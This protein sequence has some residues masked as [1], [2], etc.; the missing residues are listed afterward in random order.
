MPHA[1]RLR[2]VWGR[3]VRS[4]TADYRN[5]IL[6]SLAVVLVAGWGA[7]QALK[8]AER[9]AGEQL[10]T[11]QAAR[12][13]QI[14]GW[15]V[16]R[17]VDLR[18]LAAVLESQQDT[19]ERCQRRDSV[20][21]AHVAR[22]LAAF[23]D[24][25]G[26]QGI[27]WLS[28]G[29]EGTRRLGTLG[30]EAVGQQAM[31]RGQSLA[32]GDS[33]ML[34][35]DASDGR[36]T[37]VFLHRLDRP[38]GG[39]LAA[40]VD[41]SPAL[42]GML[43]LAPVRKVGTEVVLV[44][45][46]GEHAIRLE[47]DGSGRLQ[48]QRHLP[49]PRSV[50]A[51]LRSGMARVDVPF[52]ALDAQDREV[53]AVGNT[54]PR[55]DW[56][57]LAQRDRMEVLRDALPTLMQLLL[58]AILTLVGIWAL[59]LLQRQ[60]LRLQASVD[61]AQERQ[62][63]LR[64]MDLLT[65]M[66][67]HSADLIFV[68]D[69]EHRY[70]LFNPAAQRHIGM[71]LEQVL[72]RRDEDLLPPEQARVFSAQDDEVLRR[73]QSLRWDVEVQQG[74]K[75]HL[76]VVKSP[77]R[78]AQGQVYGLVGIA[79]DNTEAKEAEERLRG[80]EARFRALFEASGVAFFIQDLMTGDLLEA[81]LQALV[82]ARCTTLDELAS[83][84][85]GEPPYS[86]AD[87][88]AATTRLRDAWLRGDRG[89]SLR[90]E[91][92]AQRRDG[93]RYWQDLQ[94]KVVELQGR[95][96]LL[97][98]AMNIDERKRIES[99][100]YKL[101]LA[102]DQ[103]PVSALITDPS[104][105]IEYAN[106]SFMNSSGYSPR[107]VIGSKAN[108]LSSGQT[109]R[110]TYAAMWSALARGES[111]RGQVKNRRKNGEVYTDDIAIYPLRQE[112]GR[113]SHYVGL[114][115][116]ISQRLAMEGELE[117]H[118]HHLEDLIS[119]RTAQL[120]EATRRAEEANA[121]KSAFLANMSHEIRTPM[122]AV[123]GS[124]RLIQR[125]LEA[126]REVAPESAVAV[127]TGRVAQVEHAARHLLGLLNDLLDLSKIEANKLQL[128]REDFA[129]APLV[130]HLLHMVRER[131][132]ANRV[133]LV[134]DLEGV[135]ATLH[136]DGMRVS[137]MLL[138]LLANAVRFTQD[139][140]VTLRARARRAEDAVMW[141]RFEV[142]DEGIGIDEEQQARLFQAFGQAERDTARRYGG[143]GLGLAIT[144]RLAELMAGQV[145]VSS[146]LGEGSCFWLD[147]PLDAGHAAAPPPA[148]AQRCDEAIQAL[149]RLGPRHVLLVDDMAIN[150]DIARD[151]LEDAG[152]QVTV[153]GDGD[154]AVALAQ[155]QSFDLVLMDLR[156]PRMG[157]MEATRLIRALPGHAQTP[158]IALTA[159]AF[160][161]DRE[162]C[163]KAGMND[164]L[165]KPVLPERLYA[166]L[167]RWLQPA[168]ATGVAPTL[169]S[170]VAP[171]VGRPTPEPSTA[172]GVSSELPPD[173]V[174]R[175]GEI[176]GLDLAVARRLL[177][178]RLARLPAL[179]ARF[180][181][182][183][184]DAADRLQAALAG[185]DRESA[186]RLAHSLKGTSA[187]LGLHPISERAGEVERALREGQPVDLERL[188]SRLERDAPRLA[189]LDPPAPAS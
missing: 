189:A 99:E 161:E 174:Q 37:L 116:D 87:M 94:L 122:N 140:K 50:A 44:R 82:D 59:T 181:R 60:G 170:T 154:E 165:G 57:A 65:G 120:L 129:L 35:F 7:W 26:F 16:E 5:A 10:M 166:C 45:W 54:V 127:L 85:F 1:E 147:L 109:P 2:A 112:D 164:H 32:P 144:K 133:E 51:L 71:S 53:I 72:G 43:G 131:A 150:Q 134:V 68:K 183:Q 173:L 182:E 89:A 4:F 118:R 3:H 27:V 66:A 21:D 106:A 8:H 167:L 171:E 22:T 186:A 91:W 114:Q 84:Q 160:D 188:R 113:I 117:Q 81:N 15:L 187:S 157:G 156:M 13:A 178:R 34:G 77:L 78:D 169:A 47:A 42:H 158:V 96:C 153:A 49:S 97:G 6:A 176:D 33:A 90:L 24:N 121:S 142:Q 38:E 56:W 163:R 86:A 138:N 123:L 175:L 23:R 9:Q 95:P 67:A 14:E 155:R 100:L 162:A 93:S 141:V 76:S 151:L 98:A 110:E 149:R 79:R 101:S 105:V 63:R 146:R 159:Q 58:A 125:D 177:G 102:L 168:V 148:P 135:P 132:N 143:T 36:P 136:G 52:T 17:Q 64:A 41:P 80:S 184:A 115:Q 145:G 29:H 61:L 103:S 39:V 179:L 11:E 172:Q 69:L 88:R 40:E 62:E 46:E 152:L 104:G 83:S 70:L 119:Q 73:G 48:L 31:A 124:T 12:A 108:M 137:Q 25:G 75:R 18:N 185:G 107:E 19:D 74:G 28:G 20:C 30:S 126:L 130:D 128:L 55:T 111:W 180:G 139:G 92:L